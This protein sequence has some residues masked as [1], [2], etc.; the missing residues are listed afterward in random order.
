MPTRKKAKSKNWLDDA[1]E[2]ESFIGSYG[3]IYSSHDRSGYVCGVPGNVS[4]HGRGLFALRRD[5]RISR[6]AWA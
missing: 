4:K 1:S 2:G 6:Q 3:R 5:C